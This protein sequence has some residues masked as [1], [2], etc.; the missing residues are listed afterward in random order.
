MTRPPLVSVVI[1]AYRSD[2]GIAGCLSALQSQTFTDFETIVV[3]SSPGDETRRIVTE[4][5]P[6]VTF[7]E[8]PTRLLPHAARN[9]GVQIARGRLLVFT[10]ADCRPAPDWIEQCVAA[11]A[12]GH[13]VV[14]GSIEP[15]EQSWFGL[16]VHL[17]KYSFRLKGLPPGQCAIAG[18]ANACYSQTAFD[19]A[20]PFDGEVYSG[21]A[22]LAWRA[23]RRGWTPWFEPQA[24]VRHGYG[25]TPAQ[26]WRERW[27]RGVDF[28]HARIAEEGWSRARLAAYLLAFPVLPVVQ[29]ARGGRDAFRA[30]WGLVYVATLPVQALGHLAW[31]LGEAQAGLSRLR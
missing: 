8:S 30:G 23:A 10:D 13:E 2:T 4:E 18:T 27:A 16:G 26:F 21:D 22:V 19:A 29:L 12:A 9:R 24:L 14:C 17:C 11:Q 15:D 3:N 7:V 6:A 28:G 5:F 31:S 1:A 20:G 25:H